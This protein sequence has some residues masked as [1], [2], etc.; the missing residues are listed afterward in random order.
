MYSASKLVRYQ[1]QN[2][3]DQLISMGKREH[4]LAYKTI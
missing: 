4:T 1:N 2:P 3:A